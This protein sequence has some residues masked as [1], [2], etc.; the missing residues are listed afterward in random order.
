MRSKSKTINDVF[1]VPAAA[2]LTREEAASYLRVTPA[3]VSELIRP[4]CS[5]PLPFVKIGKYVRFRRA[6]L[7]KYA[8][9]A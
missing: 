6:D 3:C 5:R 7:E 8:G 1:A 2:I 4:R 9:A